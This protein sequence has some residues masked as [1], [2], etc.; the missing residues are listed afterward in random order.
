MYCINLNGTLRWKTLL[1]ISTTPNVY[2]PRV[3]A[4]SIL[5][6]GQSQTNEIIVLHSVNGTVKWKSLLGLYTNY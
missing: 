2:S 5:S 3:F 1:E 4:G 6:N